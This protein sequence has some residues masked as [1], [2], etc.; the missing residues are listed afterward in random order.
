MAYK[1][2]MHRKWTADKQAW[3]SAELQEPR[4]KD[5]KYWEAAYKICLQT[6]PANVCI[7]LGLSTTLLHLTLKRLQKAGSG[8]LWKRFTDHFVLITDLFI[9][10]SCF[11]LFF[12][13]YSIQFL[14]FSPNSSS[15]NKVHRNIHLFI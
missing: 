10:Y 6:G 13:Y 14:F 7:V 9:N 15:I 1:L 3:D 5:K 4:S 8:P 2:K 11:F 12:H